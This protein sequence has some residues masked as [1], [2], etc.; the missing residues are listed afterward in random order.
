[1]Q[2]RCNK[3]LLTGLPGCGKTTAIM[4]I[5]NQI[6]GK[7]VT[8]FYTQEIRKGGRREGFQW[9]RLDGACDVLAH[10][11][12]KSA[13]KVGRYGVDVKTFEQCVVPYLDISK[14]DAE[15]FV[16][17][18]I[19]KMECFCERFVQAVRQLFSCD[20]TVIA[21]VAQKGGG[22]I[23]ELKHL[24]NTKL[25]T[26]TRTN[27]SEVVAQILEMLQAAQKH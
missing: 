15:V 5:V 17:D 6:Q 19:G 21:T 14:T 1:M 18:E 4:H 7:S 27:R 23:S 11:D 8:G 25:F 9:N 22:L 16:I 26:L 24:P 2:K 10:V 20:K 3:I 13:R 12:F